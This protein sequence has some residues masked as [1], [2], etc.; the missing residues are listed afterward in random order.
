[1]PSQATDPPPLRPQ[2][3][4]V[5]VCTKCGDVTYS[6]QLIGLIHRC[7]NVPDKQQGIWAGRLC[8]HDWLACLSCEAT[9]SYNGNRCELCG[10]IGWIDNRHP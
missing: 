2:P 1:M 10:G 8:K 6:G 5:A 4:P 3:K 7:L 9:G